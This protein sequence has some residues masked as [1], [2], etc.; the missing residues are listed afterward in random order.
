[1]GVISTGCGQTNVWLPPSPQKKILYD[2]PQETL[3]SEKNI[4]EQ[5]LV[6]W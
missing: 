2:T 6:E 1:M 5:N 3:T 4:Q